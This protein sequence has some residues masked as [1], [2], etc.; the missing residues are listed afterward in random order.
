M[1]KE[2]WGTCITPAPKPEGKIV[3]AQEA[4]NPHNKRKSELKKPRWRTMERVKREMQTHGGGVNYMPR[5]Q[6]KE[7]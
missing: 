6:T 4:S 2:A 3:M 1:C 5:R 7:K